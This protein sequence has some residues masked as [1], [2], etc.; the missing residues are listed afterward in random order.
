MKILVQGQYRGERIDKVR[1][2]KTYYFL[3]IGF[4]LPVTKYVLVGARPLQSNSLK[5]LKEWID[6]IKDEMENL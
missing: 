6:E 5:D 2:W 4:R 1:T 3:G